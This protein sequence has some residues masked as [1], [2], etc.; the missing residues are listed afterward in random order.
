MKKTKYF[1]SLSFS[2]NNN[3]IF[4][5]TQL[6]EIGLCVCIWVNNLPIKQGIVTPT[7]FFREQQKHLERLKNSNIPYETGNEI[8][9]TKENGFWKEAKS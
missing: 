9:V 5:Q 8:T 2:E 6:Y 3:K 1:E 4:I 7:A